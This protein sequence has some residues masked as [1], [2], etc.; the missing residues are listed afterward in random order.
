VALLS[1]FLRHFRCHLHHHLR[2]IVFAAVPLFRCPVTVVVVVI[3]VAITVTI[4]VS[5]LLPTSPSASS[6]RC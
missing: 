4:I 6:R 2:V 3:A 5:S 1:L